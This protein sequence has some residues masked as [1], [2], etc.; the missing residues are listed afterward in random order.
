MTDAHGRR[1]IGPLTSRRSLIRSGL[2][3]GGGSLLAAGHWRPAGAAQATPVA[4]ASEEAATTIVGLAQ[5]AMTDYALKA[6]ILRVTIDGQ[7]VVTAALG[8]SMTGVPATPA[9]HFRNGA[10][11][12]SY[13]STVLLQLVDQGVVTLDDAIATWMPDLPNAEQVTL[14]MLANMTSGYP[15][16]V[17]DDEFIA[18]FY[19]DP[20]R[21]VTTEQQL[22]Y[23]FK[24]PPIFEPGTNW[25]YAHT[26]YVILG[27]I[28]ERITGR[29]LADLIRDWVLI[30]LRLR[31]TQASVTAEIPEPVLHAFSSERRSPLGIPAGTRFYEESTFWNPSWTLAHGAIE[32]TDIYDMAASA[33]AIGTGSLLSPASHQAQIDPGLLG[34]GAPLEG[35][36]ACLTMDDRRNYGLGVWLQGNWI[37]QNPL[38]GGFGGMMAYLPARRLSMAIMVT[39][40]EGSFGD[41]GNYRFGNASEQLYAAIGAALAPES[42]PPTPRSR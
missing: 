9:M 28:M 18:E 36:P 41:D 27:Q 37:V 11:A 16:Y 1:D 26:N 14:R 7:E 30:P 40:G 6:V 35:C 5:Q 13:M 10:V 33:E 4:P 17:Q 24:T 42:P 32:T 8:E 23:A 21:H 3:L 19:A 38:F 12:I 34:F 31:G 2:V 22:A 25:N 15:D 39:F 29:P 20:F